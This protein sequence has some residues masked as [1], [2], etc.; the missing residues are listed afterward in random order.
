[1]TAL[2]FPTLPARPPKSPDA[3]RPFSILPDC[4][5][6]IAA[7][8]FEKHPVHIPCPRGLRPGELTMVMQ[9]IWLRGKGWGLI[10]VEPVR[11]RARV[12]YFELSWRKDL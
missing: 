5:Q 8:S 2:T 1:M 11:L 9:E 3:G 6:P 4:L 12:F 7:V 10:R